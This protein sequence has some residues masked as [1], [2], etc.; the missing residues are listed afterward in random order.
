MSKKEIL[1]RTFSGLG[2]EIYDL[3]WPEGSVSGDEL[4]YKELLKKHQGISLEVG[5]GTGRILI[6]FLK[7]NLQVDGLDNS[8]DMIKI[9]K[10]KLSKEGLNTNLYESQM[11][12]F[13]LSKRYNNIYIPFHSFMIVSDRNEAFQALSCFFN[14]LKEN[15]QLIISLFV[16]NY[17]SLSMYTE[18]RD[19]WRYCKEIKYKNNQKI[20]I[21]DAVKN[22]HF[23]QIKRV[24]YRFQIF[25]DTQLIDT[26][27]EEMKVRWYFRYEFQLMLENIGFRNIKAYG[28]FTLEPLRA[29]HREMTFQAFKP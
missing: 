6:P 13:N 21:S 7:E 2:A 25:D 26:F 12:N 11:Q 24:R 18:D 14:H 27:V 5:C 20:I 16:P 10:D 17:Q 9:C 8:G 29:G 23:E 3:W 22:S 15:G 28:D 1:Q 19:E 4:F